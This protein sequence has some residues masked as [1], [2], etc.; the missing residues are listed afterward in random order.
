MSNNA[1]PDNKP[2]IKS[3]AEDAYDGCGTAQDD[4]GLKQTRQADLG[5]LLTAIKGTAPSSPLPPGAPPA[6]PAPP[7]APGLDYLYDEA[8]LATRQAKAA[9]KAKDEEVYDFLVAARK[10]LETP[11]GK[12]WS[13]EWV[14]AG[15]NNEPGSTAVP[16]TQNKR[17]SSINTLAIYLAQ[18]PTYQVPG[19][20]PHTEVT[21]T[22]A[23]A[24]HSQLSDARQ[25][26]SDTKQAQMNAETARDAAYTALRKRLI[27]LVD[28]LTLLIGPADQRWEIFGF[29]IPANPRVPE[30]A[31][32][33][34]LTLAG[35]GRIIAEWVRGTRSDDNRV[36][37]QV[38][39]VDTEYREYSKS[40]NTTEEVIKGMA[41][42]T[43]VKV[44]I[45][46][47]NGSL[48]AS[49]GPEAQISV[50]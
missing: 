6:P 19:G 17:F 3:M 50:P 16:D 11:L 23:Q 14:L 27:A 8:K 28:E 34:L 38:I 36:L 21:A 40:G 24:L 31:T 41:S 30:P 44:N 43:T 47:L 33:L 35:D 46:A 12:R 39:G 13:P 37:I 22:R 4:V 1:I 45:I 7:P 48:E 32:Q 42:G 2:I 18:H 15:F 49:S 5:S 29:N 10:V 9:H 20:T 25:A 26:M